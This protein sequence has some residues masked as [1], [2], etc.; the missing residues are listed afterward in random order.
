[1]KLKNSKIHKM[2]NIKMSDDEDFGEIKLKH[3]V[4]NLD[5]YDSDES[6]EPDFDFEEPDFDFRER[7]DSVDE[8]T[9]ENADV[10]NALLSEIGEAEPISNN[11]IRVDLHNPKGVKFLKK[12]EDVDFDNNEHGYPLI[13]VNGEEFI[14]PFFTQLKKMRKELKGTKIETNVSSI[15]FQF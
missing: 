6:E 8:K 5:I 2:K 7:K 10:L 15:S 11:L 13:P 14:L 12:S 3:T 9:E 4:A 1:M